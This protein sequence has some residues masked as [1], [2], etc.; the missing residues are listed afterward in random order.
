MKTAII[1]AEGVKQIV[2]TPENDDEKFAL[3]LIAPSDDIELLITEGK[4]G[5]IRNQPFTRT[6]NMCAGGYLR[7]FDDAESRIFVLTPKDKSDGKKGK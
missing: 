6:V 2:F 4:I 7:I 3:S 1:F 5:D